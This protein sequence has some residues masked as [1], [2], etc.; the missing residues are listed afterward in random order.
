MR[1]R[2][3]PTLTNKLLSRT[4][5]GANAISTIRVGYVGPVGKR[6]NVAASSL[7]LTSMMAFTVHAD[8]D[9]TIYENKGPQDFQPVPDSSS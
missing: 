3:D 4:S 6:T 5:L 2:A 7:T 9:S 8:V 1:A